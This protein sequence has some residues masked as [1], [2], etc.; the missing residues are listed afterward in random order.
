[1]TIKDDVLA[2]FQKLAP[3]DDALWNKDGTPKLEAIRNAAGD[4]KISR[5]EMI[6]SIGDKRRPEVKAAEPAEGDGGAPPT[7]EATPPATPPAPA[8]DERPDTV[9][10]VKPEVPGV[11][12]TE[13]PDKTKLV[14][15]AQS[16]IADIEKE[17]ATITP[18]LADTLAEVERLKGLREKEQAV[19]DANTVLLTHA[20]AVKKVQAQ[21]QAN[22]A[23]NKE[24][25]ALAQTALAASGFKP[26]PSQLDASLQGRKRTP[27]S[28]AAQATYYKQQGANRLAERLGQ[29]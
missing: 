25:M 16:N 17:L 4:Q 12:D 10:A 26:A 6:G 14:A 20:E 13:T 15:E 27:E 3:N 18:G 21:T 24:R 9:N 2:A 8:A 22:I 5:D 23:A 19:V 28:I 7:Q 29:V 11:E 1:M